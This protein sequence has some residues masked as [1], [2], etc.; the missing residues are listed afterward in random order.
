MTGDS[1]EEYTQAVLALINNRTLL[2]QYQNSSLA[3]S[4]I[5]TLDNMVTNFVNGI[6]Q[7]LR[8]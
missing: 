5:Y 1:V 7:C 6:S 8:H 3:D 2:T 4:E